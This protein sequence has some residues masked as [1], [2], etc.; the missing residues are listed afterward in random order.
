MRN[1]NGAGLAALALV[2]AFLLVV[3]FHA[4]TRAKVPAHIT[5]SLSDGALLKS[6]FEGLR[7]IPAYT[8]GKMFSRANQASRRDCGKRPGLLSRL[9]AS[10]GLGTVVHAQGSRSSPCEDCYRVQS[11]ALCPGSC[12][13]SD[14]YDV[15]IY[16]GVCN[17]GMELAGPAC[18]TDGDCYCNEA[19]GCES[20]CCQ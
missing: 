20:N 6:F 9:A 14:T 13:E 1:F 11:Q 16:G 19:A 8:S 17:D 18:A 5:L 3:Q 10:V 12:S 2:G 15:A 4:P 7:P